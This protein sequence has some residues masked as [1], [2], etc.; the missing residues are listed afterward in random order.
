MY[1]NEKLTEFVE[2]NNEL[3]KIIEY[4]GRVISENGSHIPRSRTRALLKRIFMRPEKWSLENITAHLGKCIIIW[5]FTL[6]LYLILYFRLLKRFL[7]LLEQ[8]S[9]RWSNQS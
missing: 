6:M 5:C 9:S 1:H 3:D 4:K 7:D 2:N 8:L